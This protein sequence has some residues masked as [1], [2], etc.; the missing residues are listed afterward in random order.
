MIIFASITTPDFDK[1]DQNLSR[2][3]KFEI[4]IEIESWAGKSNIL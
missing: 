1:S 2:Y 3:F 4:E